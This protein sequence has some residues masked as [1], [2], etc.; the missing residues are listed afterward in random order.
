MEWTPAPVAPLR[1]F[2]GR[3]AARLPGIAGPQG[4]EAQPERGGCL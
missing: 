4:S 1:T 3:G 2:E